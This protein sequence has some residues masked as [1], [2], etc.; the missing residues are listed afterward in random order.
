ML[1]HGIALGFV[2]P[3]TE[4]GDEVTIDVRGTELLGRVVSCPFYKKAI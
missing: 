1:E 4:I 2:Q 3:N